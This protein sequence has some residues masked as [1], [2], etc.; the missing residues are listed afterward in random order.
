MNIR[1]LLVDDEPLARERLRALLQS[2]ERFHVLAEA[3]D[4]RSALQLIEDLAP[5][6]VFLDIQMPEMTGI[7]VAAALQAS[8]SKLPL[9]VFVTAYDNFALQAFDLHAIDYLLKPFDRARFETA[10]DKAAS[11]LASHTP[12]DLSHQLAALISTYRSEQRL[13]NRLPIKTDGRVILLPV[14]EIDWIGAAN[15]YVE[16]HAGKACHLMRETMNAIEERLDPARFLRISRSTLV[17]ID[18]IREIQPLFY[19]EHAVILADGAK[20]TA[21]RGYRDALKPLLGK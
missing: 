7:E 20:L 5:D 18:R 3:A 15:N 14:E 2:D 6:L 8:E 21:S 17:A 16:I 12:A 9:I 13:P 11:R 10:L 1:C 4:G 19:G